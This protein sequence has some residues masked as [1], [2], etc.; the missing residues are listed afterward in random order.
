[1]ALRLIRSVCLVVFLAGTFFGMG[2]SYFCRKRVKA[3]AAPVSKAVGRKDAS[4]EA[5]LRENGPTRILLTQTGCRAHL[6]T[7]CA[8][9]AHSAEAVE[10][11]VCRYCLAGVTSL[12]DP[13][14]DELALRRR[15][16]GSET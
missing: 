2:V 10:V 15:R 9:L 1:M 3:R 6:L 7:D 13:H 11:L 4:G 12:R 14:R 5:L 16:V 8:S